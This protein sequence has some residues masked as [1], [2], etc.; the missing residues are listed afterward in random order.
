MKNIQIVFLLLVQIYICDAQ[1]D[2]RRDKTFDPPFC[3]I[4]GRDAA[5]LDDN[6]ILIRHSGISV[7]CTNNDQY[8]YF[9][10]IN[11]DD[12]SFYDDFNAE[13]HLSYPWF[14]TYVEPYFYSHG[15]GKRGASIRFHKDGW[16]DSSYFL[17]DIPQGSRR[18]T[19]DVLYLPD[20][21]RILL[22]GAFIDSIAQSLNV[23]PQFLMIDREDNI[24]RSIR[25]PILSEPNPPSP[26]QNS[27]HTASIDLD[28]LNNKVY[29]LTN[30]RFADGHESL[31]FFRMDLNGNID[32]S[33]S[34]EVADPIQ[35]IVRLNIDNISFVQKNGKLILRGLIVI[36]EDGVDYAVPMIR[37]NLDGSYDTT[38]NALNSSIPYVEWEGDETVIRNYYIDELI[39]WKDDMYIITGAFLEYQGKP[40]K[41][42]AVIDEDGNLVEDYFRDGQGFGL[43]SATVKPVIYKLLLA[44]PD[45]LYVA[46]VFTLFDDEQTPGI[47]RLTLQDLSTHVDDIE[48][49]NSEIN[50]FPN[51]ASDQLTVDIGN[52]PFDQQGHIRIV[53]MK[54]I[55]VM[56]T[57]LQGRTQMHLNIQHL[58]PG[59]Y[60]LH[61][62]KHQ[63]VLQK[64]S[65]VKGS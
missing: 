3:I 58:P 40:R 32:T 46:G 49:A 2:F 52:I 17:L 22:S 16:F 48:K 53:N 33:F 30:A 12:G 60:H 38:F 14:Y 64:T 61:L 5:I 6:S 41:H 63:R 15:R 50:V 18:I 19:H 47:I 7:L 28:D 35:R 29:F 27:I 57:P 4:N 34:F 55:E 11:A 37:L 13:G 54:G 9:A 56:H 26:G 20:N 59:L 43:E 51:P 42:I 65:F 36:R 25:F 21:D 8:S 62:Y 39:Y 44:E 1:L 24:D 45:S 10:R 23:H 31:N